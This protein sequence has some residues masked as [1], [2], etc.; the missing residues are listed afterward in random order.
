MKICTKCKI[1]KTIEN[2]SLKHGKCNGCRKIEY[3][4]KYNTRK[5]RGCN[6]IKTRIDFEGSDR[7]CFSCHNI[8]NEREKESKRKGAEKYRKKYPEKI[9]NKNQK[10]YK[11]K[12]YS[13]NPLQ[14]L[15]YRLQSCKKR[16]KDK[17]LQFE[18][19]LE[20]LNDLYSKQS[21]RCAL[22]NIIF[23][24]VFDEKFSKRPFSPS[25]DRIDS[26]IGY[27][28]SN[29]RLVCGAVNYALSEYGD[30]IFDTICESRIQYK[31]QCI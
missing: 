3:Q 4:E 1:Q 18:L 24:F 25:V 17:K 27:I 23:D 28:K 14:I 15:N 26:K 12:Y 8:R 5:C 21:G 13:D 11:R 2:F 22:T 7:Y 10:K 31:N 29:V 9:K 30:Q 19:D 20:F 6:K 16:A